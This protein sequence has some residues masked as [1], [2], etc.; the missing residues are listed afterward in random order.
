MAQA[1]K[2]EA[3]KNGGGRCTKPAKA[4]SRYCHWHGSVVLAFVRSNEGVIAIVVAM[5]ALLLGEYRAYTSQ[6]AAAKI[7]ERI[8]FQ[9]AND[10]LDEA[11]DALGW[12][13]YSSAIHPE[14]Y[15]VADVEKARRLIDSAHSLAP[16]LPRTKIL[17][18][19]LLSAQ[20]KRNEASRALIDLIAEHPDYAI[21]HNNLGNLHNFMGNYQQG[22][23]EC[24]RAIKLDPTLGCAF[25]NKSLSLFGLGRTDEALSTLD[26]AIACE[27][28]NIVYRAHKGKHLIRTRRFKDAVE[29]LEL[30]VRDRPLSA[31]YRSDLGWAYEGIGNL[32]N[33]IAM[34][35]EAVRI[36]QNYAH[37]RNNLGNCLSLS[38]DIEG[39]LR[40]FMAAARL[41]PG[42]AIFHQNCG[43]M[44][45]KLEKYSEAIKE[46]SEATVLDPTLEKAWEEKILAQLH[47]KQFG[48]A[49]R[50]AA[51]AVACNP[52]SVLLLASN[53]DAQAQAGDIK[54]AAEMYGRAF[55][56]LQEAE[57][58]QWDSQLVTRIVLNWSSTL[59]ETGEHGIA[60]AALERVTNVVQNDARLWSNL[61]VFYRRSGRTEDALRALG[62]DL[63]LNP[64]SPVALSSRGILLAEAGKYEEALRDIDAAI[65]I[66]GTAA[67]LRFNRAVV[68]LALNRKE[69]AENEQAIGNRLKSEQGQ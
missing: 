19:T 31:E 29:I 4:G 44:L 13:R 23:V 62:A 34:H 42:R 12:E 25:Y 58:E 17:R 69:E 33:A 54:M 1:N 7:Q 45:A 35:T 64:N 36:D 41:D 38:G 53:A 11:W 65:A 55:A 22:L 56:L 16:T 27:P 60:I 20:G 21:A 50:T 49:L 5:S 48:E 66:D 28:T 15:R 8:D 47:L 30:V 63:A 14:A 39:A 43:L 10:K 37:A 68:L 52:K 18:A 57:R 32:P 67:Q 9:Q 3:T 6:R 24:E 59:L 40:E 61:S 46:L 51:D 2:C 26:E